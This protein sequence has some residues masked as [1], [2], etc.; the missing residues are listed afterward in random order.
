MDNAKVVENIA[1][2]IARGEVIVA[3]NAT[4]GKYPNERQSAPQYGVI[5][6]G[7]FDPCYTASEAAAVFVRAV[8]GAKRA[9]RVLKYHISKRGEA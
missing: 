8:G 4:V 2:R 5:V 9:A 6:A 3:P 1:S 7:H